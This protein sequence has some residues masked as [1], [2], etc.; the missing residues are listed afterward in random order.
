[1]KHQPLVYFLSEGLDVATGVH[2]AAAGPELMH[3][4][5]SAAAAK[6]DSFCGRGTLSLSMAKFSSPYS[7]T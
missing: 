7:T 3:T 2:Y 6:V 1:M 5:D 4:N